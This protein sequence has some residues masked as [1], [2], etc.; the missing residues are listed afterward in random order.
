MILR[1][2]NKIPCA[3]LCFGFS[4][5]GYGVVL[6]ILSDPVQRMVYDEIHGY[7]VTAT[8]PFLDDS[9]PKDHVFVD[10]FACI[11]I[12]ICLKFH[13]REGKADDLCLL[14]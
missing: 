1:F 9:S 4:L 13:L 11:G 7:A 6:Q 14:V 5:V 3:L 12:N 2:C 10:E 8:N